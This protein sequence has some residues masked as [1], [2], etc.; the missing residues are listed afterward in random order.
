[1]KYHNMFFAN[2][3]KKNS[4]VMEGDF[5]VERKNQLRTDWISIITCYYI[6]SLHGLIRVFE[7]EE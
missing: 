7:R 2:R 1:M 3:M 4:G 5:V 6:V